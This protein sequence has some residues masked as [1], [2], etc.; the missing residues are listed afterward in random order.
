MIA[1]SQMKNPPRHL[2]LGQIAFD[3][4]VEDRR[5]RLAEI[6]TL[7]DMSVAADFPSD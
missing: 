5:Q 7:R 4:I 3:N 2:P 6:E 1:I